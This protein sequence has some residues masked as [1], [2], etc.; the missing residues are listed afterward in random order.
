M[1]SGKAPVYSYPVS[2]VAESPEIS[3]SVTSYPSS[4]ISASSYSV[5]YGSSYGGSHSGGDYESF[6]PRRAGIDVVDELSDRMNSAFDPIRMDR[7]LAKQAQTLV[8]SVY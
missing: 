4:R 7:S 3:D 5:P 6:S 8:I 1:P 2:R